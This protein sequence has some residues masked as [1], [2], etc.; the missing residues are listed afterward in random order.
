M[1]K[2]LL[3]IPDISGFTKFVQSTEIS[4]SQFVIAE[5]LE[6]LISANT[7][8]LKLAEV[9]GDALFFYKEGDIP[10]QEKLLAQI[11]TMFTAFY[12]HLKLLEKNRICPCNACASAPKL[13]LKIVAH[14]GDE[15]QFLTVQGNKKP[16]GAPVI[17]AH[18]LLKN[19]VDSDNYVLISNA[20]AGGLGLSKSYNSMLFNFEEKEDTYDGKSLPYLYAVIDNKRLKTKSYPEPKPVTFN[21]EPDIFFEKEFPLSAENFLELLTNY[22]YRGH[23]T[24]GVDEFKYNETEV[25]RLGSEHTCVI[26]G[27]HFNFVTVSKEVQPNELIYG[28]Q[29]D[30]PPVIDRATQF[31][32]ISPID[33]HNCR[34]N[35]E[36]FI[37]AKSIWKKI[38]VALMVRKAFRKNIRKAM[39]ALHRF[40]M[41]KPLNS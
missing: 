18:R 4:H 24:D 11:E 37:E 2:S 1:A 8:D 14:V 12:S 22:K 25:T 9:E 10:S 20:L 15:L 28:E 38:L 41:T 5:L 3:F 32:I 26:D 35:I 13:E 39:D 19:S 21:G 17:E 6:I 27:K 16:F 36:I 29:T 33:E 7:Q 23:W 40:A 34:V 30:G 31:Y